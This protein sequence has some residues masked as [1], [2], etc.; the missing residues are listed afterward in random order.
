[1]V[2]VADT[3]YF[4]FG[5][6]PTH[7]YTVIDQTPVMREKPFLVCDS[8]GVYSVQKPG[9][10]QNVPSDW[11][12]PTTSFLDSTAPKASIPITSFYIAKAGTDT[13]DTLNAA[14]Q[15]GYHLIF[16]PGIYHLSTSINV[17]WPDTILMGLG[18]ATLIPDNSTPAIVVN[19][20][21]GV[22]VSGL[23]ID[24]GATAPTNNQPLLLVGPSTSNRADHSAD[25]TVLFDICCRVGGASAGPTST[26]SCV[27]INS[28]NVLMDNMWL[29][30]AD[31]GL[32]NSV[33]WSTNKAVNG[34]TVNGDN[35]IAYGL[36]V[37]HFQAYQT[38]WNGNGG[39]VYFYQSEIPYD[40]PDQNTWRPASD[41]VKGYAS[42]KVADSVDTHTAQ[43]LGVYCYFRDAVV[44]LDRA[45]ETPTN[46]DGVK[47]QHMVTFWL[48]GM[49]GSSINHVVN[50]LGR[51]VT[52]DSRKAQV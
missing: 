39:Q 46:K 50:G 42:Y 8:N 12:Q 17:T 41:S 9:I 38:V 44:Q 48:D 16:T 4:P 30:R 21:D 14:L 35:V 15:T 18:V 7:A 22:T 13:A 25:P 47:L 32:P 31:H 2:F 11:S 34:L 23:I 3:G 28:N 20:V 52:Q 43:G 27:T 24:A 51:A 49:A 6:W 26:S 36:F 40:V 5:Q 19:D 1:M 10:R 33:G 37:E 45:I 29:W